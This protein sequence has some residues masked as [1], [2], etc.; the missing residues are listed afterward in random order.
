[1]KVGKSQSWVTKSF[2]MQTWTFFR[3]KGDTINNFTE[4][5]YF[6]NYSF[7][8]LERSQVRIAQK[9]QRR[10]LEIGRIKWNSN[11]GSSEKIR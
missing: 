5:V 8:A 10:W 9:Q 4:A 1:M 7:P 3:M 2:T 11:M 6:K